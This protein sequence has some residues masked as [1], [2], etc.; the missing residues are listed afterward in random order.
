MAMLCNWTS[1][2]LS[3]ILI[4]HVFKVFVIVITNSLFYMKR[5]TFTTFKHDSAVAGAGL[6]ALRRILRFVVGVIFITGLMTFW[7]V[8]R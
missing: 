3:C 1:P 6:I 8:R 4:S 5:S 2:Q 7:V